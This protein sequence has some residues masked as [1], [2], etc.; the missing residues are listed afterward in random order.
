MMMMMMMMNAP[1]IVR[2]KRLT[3]VPPGAGESG[4]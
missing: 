2:E 4:S 1:L 3:Y